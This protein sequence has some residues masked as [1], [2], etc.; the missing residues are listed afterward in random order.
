MV[1]EV[2]RTGTVAGTGIAL[3]GLPL[4]FERFWRVDRAGAHSHSPTTSGIPPE[5]A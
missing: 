5:R 1:I 2:T 3:E 4:V